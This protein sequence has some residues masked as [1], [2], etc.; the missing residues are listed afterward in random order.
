[1]QV[2]D[3]SFQCLVFDIQVG[4]FRL[5]LGNCVRLWRGVWRHLVSVCLQHSHFFLQCMHPLLLK[6]KSIFKT[7][8]KC[9][10]YIILQ[11]V[12]TSSALTFCFMCMTCSS[13]RR[14]SSVAAILSRPISSSNSILVSSDLVIRSLSR[15]DS[16]SASLWMRSIWSGR[17][18][19]GMEAR[20]GRR[21]SEREDGWWIK[22]KPRGS[23]CFPCL[24]KH[25][26]V[27]A[28]RTRVYLQAQ[29]MFS[30]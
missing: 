30:H 20:Q 5:Q 2:F 10:F 28:F 23:W 14:R 16:F 9:I 27:S 29:N 3:F 7:S 1:M 15:R 18:G 11:R 12:T 6:T 17:R 25:P 8:F 4:I 26:F 13:A 19:G 22:H 21:M 24:S